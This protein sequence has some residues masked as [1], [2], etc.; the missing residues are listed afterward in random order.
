MN[1]TRKVELLYKKAKG[2]SIDATPGE[3]AELKKY[4]IS[5]GDGDFHTTKANVRAYVDAVDQEG[6][7]ISFYDWCMNHHRADKRRKGSSSREI[8]AVNR[9]QGLGAMFLGWL[10]WGIAVYWIFNARMTVGSSAI[11]G[12]V[13]AFTLVRVARRWMFFNLFILPAIV[14]AFVN[15]YL[16]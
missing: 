12:A 1:K 5:K 2:Q 3:L 13:I 16:L 8:A 11:I 7:R 9:Q 10:T 14:A 4:K 15:T 6:C